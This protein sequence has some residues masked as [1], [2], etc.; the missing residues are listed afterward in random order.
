MRGATLTRIVAI[1]SDRRECRRAIELRKI[2]VAAQTVLE[3]LG[4]GDAVVNQRFAA[5]VPLLDEGVANGQALAPDRRAPVRA[6]AH[7]REGGDVVRQFLRLRADLAIRHDIFAEADPETLLR[8]NLATSQDDLERTTLADDARE[9]HGAAVDQGHTPAPAVNAKVSVF[10]HHPEVAP[11]RELHPPGDGR[12]GHGR[13]DRFVQLEPRR[14]QRTPR[15]F[16]AVAA[17]PGGRN[18]ELAQRMASIERADV[19]QVPS[20]A[21]GASFAEEHRD[22]CRLIRIEF[23]KCPGQC[24]GA[25]GIH[26]V[27]RLGAAVN[28]GPDGSA[29]FDSDGHAGFSSI[30]QA[31]TEW[32]P[33]SYV[34]GLAFAPVCDRMNAYVSAASLSCCARVEPM[35][36]PASKSTRNKTGLPLTLAACNRAAILA[37]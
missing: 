18:V 29:L 28:H 15:D 13:N 31:H 6:D 19:L 4:T 3:S 11:Q 24:I 33:P 30:V 36:W 26:C 8:G 2:A 14:A 10:L 17:R 7:R 35:P 34:R 23:E 9:P 12:A 5:V 32:R 21:E 20:G 25:L 22:A 37:G 16:A 1:R 27:A